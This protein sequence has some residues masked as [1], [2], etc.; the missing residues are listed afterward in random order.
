ML[1]VTRH[2]V[3]VAEAGAFAQAA[4]SA[5]AALAVRPGFVSA[6][7]ARCLDD[8][9]L[10]VFTSTWASVGAGRRALVS[11]ETREVLMPVMASAVD[12]PSAFDLVS[13]TLG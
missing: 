7:V 3:P 6:Q 2:R 13:S 11:G 8:P 12:E 5:V 9:D 1:F 10:W 4:Q